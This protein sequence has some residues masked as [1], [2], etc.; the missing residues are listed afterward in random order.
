MNIIICLDERMGILFN[1]RRLS[2]DRNVIKDIGES[3][4]GT[5]YMAPFSEKLFEN[6]M[7]PHICAE[8]FLELAG[9]ND[10]CFVEG[11]DF[12]AYLHSIKQIT[13]YW[14][15]RHYPSDVRLDLNFAENGFTLIE[16][17]EFT[18]S[19]HEKITKEIYHR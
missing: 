11:T 17:T 13:V 19:S 6:S 4:T 14:W 3:Q 8:N 10:S 1:H 2:K 12:L 9:E 15:N 18:G 16:Q 7:I 5:L